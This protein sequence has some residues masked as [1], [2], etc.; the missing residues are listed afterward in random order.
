MPTLYFIETSKVDV[1]ETQG[2][3]FGMWGWCLDNNGP[4]EI[5]RRFCSDSLKRVFCFLLSPSE[6]GLILTHFWAQIG[7]LV[8]HSN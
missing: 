1:G 3:V 2:V 7:I 4:M 6:E 8:E 5:G